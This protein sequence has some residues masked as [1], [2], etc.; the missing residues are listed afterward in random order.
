MSFIMS[1]MVSLSCAWNRCC[2]QRSH[3]RCA[4]H[5]RAAHDC[6]RFL[7]PAGP[8]VNYFHGLMRC[9]LNPTARQTARNWDVEARAILN[10]GFRPSLYAAPPAQPPSPSTSPGWS[11]RLEYF[12]S[13]LFCLF[14]L[15]AEVPL[16]PVKR[17]PSSRPLVAP[18]RFLKHLKPTKRETTQTF[19]AEIKKRLRLYVELRC[20]TSNRQA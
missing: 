1:E 2:Q 14:K 17:P 13:A 11:V 10:T 9:S 3:R 4:D 8:P 15:C 6:L 12:S 18:A 7:V 19:R 5:D 20:M 16:E